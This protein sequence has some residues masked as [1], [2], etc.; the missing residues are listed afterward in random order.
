MSIGLPEVLLLLA[1]VLLIFG[2]SRL[3]ALAR[4]LGKSTH[5]FK[6]GMREG[7]AEEPAERPGS[8]KAADGP[9]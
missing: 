9:G 7:D 4:S 3:P 8:R 6:A 5:E 1:I 2:A